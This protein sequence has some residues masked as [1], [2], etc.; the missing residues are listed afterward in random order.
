MMIRMKKVIYSVF[1]LPFYICFP[2]F[3]SASSINSSF[4]LNLTGGDFQKQ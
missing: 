4:S 2:C 3:S 1:F